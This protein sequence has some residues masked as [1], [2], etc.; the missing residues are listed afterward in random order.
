MCSKMA[1]QVMAPMVVMVRKM[2]QKSLLSQVTTHPTSVGW[3]LSNLVY[4]GH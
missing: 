1:S 2:A 4:A 3:S